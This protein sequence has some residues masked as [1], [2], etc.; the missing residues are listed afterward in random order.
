MKKDTNY[1][2]CSL[3]KDKKHHHMA[4]IPEKFA[5]VGKYIKIKNSDDTWDDGWEVTGACSDVKK[6]SEEANAASQLYK[7]TRK[8]SDI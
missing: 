8:A 5:V 3:V 6:N 7:K 4:W 1:I 2:Q